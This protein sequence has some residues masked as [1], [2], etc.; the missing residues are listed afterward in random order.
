MTTKMKKQKT[1]EQKSPQT[2]VPPD[3]GES[4][5]D[6]AAPA[7]AVIMVTVV[8]TAKA[9]KLSPRDPGGRISYQVGRLEG[10]AYLRIYQNDSAGQFSKEW[11]PTEALRRCMT[12][13][14]LAGQPWKTRAYIPALVGRS[15]TNCGFITAVLRAEG[16][17]ATEPEKR[18]M[19]V[20]TGNLDDWERAV[21]DAEPELDGDGNVRLEPLHPPVK[22]TRFG[23]PRPAGGRAKRA[24]GVEMPGD[25]DDG[26]E[27]DTS[28]ED[29]TPGESED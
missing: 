19:S 22:D 8:R 16:L 1:H 11:V 9:P 13:A 15:S 17:A 20:L 29:A 10:V 3:G 28:D 4:I 12:P 21:L 25:D 2:D 24:R 27:P 6:S 7:A 23:G 5:N 14:M 18:G 26:A